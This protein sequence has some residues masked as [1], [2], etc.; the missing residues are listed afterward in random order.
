MSDM[1]KI[2]TLDLSGHAF[3]LFIFLKIYY[4]GLYKHDDQQSE[5]ICVCLKPSK[6]FVKLYF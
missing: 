6:D 3:F 1:P 4:S 5:C 2:P